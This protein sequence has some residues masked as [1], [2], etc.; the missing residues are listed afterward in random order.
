[1]Q[2]DTSLLD[3]HREALLQHGSPQLFGLNASRLTAEL[4]KPDRLLHDDRDFDRIR[5]VYGAPLRSASA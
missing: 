1:M 3:D 5:E 2:G 4:A